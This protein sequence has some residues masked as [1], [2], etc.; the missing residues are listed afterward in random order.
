MVAARIHR[1]GSTLAVWRYGGL[2]KRLLEARVYGSILPHLSFGKA[3]GP[4]TSLLPREWPQAEQV[5][6]GWA[7]ARK[8][9]RYGGL[10]SRVIP[11]RT[12]GGLDG[13]K[14][15]PTTRHRWRFELAILPAEVWKVWLPTS[16]RPGTGG[17]IVRRT[18]E[19]KVNGLA[20]L[21]C[22]RKRKFR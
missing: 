3:L 8:C 21:I 12:G 20:G 15:Y 7:A 4:S 9:R 6:G 13:L 14:C 5:T 10:I 22:S 16:H 2:A 1:T 18:E 17:L 11:R 19:T